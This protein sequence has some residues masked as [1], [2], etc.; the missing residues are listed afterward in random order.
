MKKLTL[1]LVFLLCGATLLAQTYLDVAP[2]YGTLNA[3]V[4]KNQGNVIYRLQAGQWYGLNGVIENNGFT[5]KIIGTTPAKGEMPAEIQTATQ[6]NGTV[7]SYMFNMIGNVT[8]KNVFIVNADANNSFGSGVFTSASTT[9]IKVVIDN[10]TVDPVGSAYGIVFNSTP[11][12]KLFI[13]NSLFIDRG[14]LNGANDGWF[15]AIGGAPNNGFDTLYVENNTFMVGGTGMGSLSSVSGSDSSNFVW[16]NHNSF[17]FQKSQ[18]FWAW[19]MNS[20]FVTNN[21]FFDFTTQPWNNK[22]NVFFP[23]GDTAGTQSRLSLVNQDT[24]LSDYT[25]GVLLSHRKLFVEYNSFYTDP[26]IQAYPTTWAAT[27]TKNND[28]V[29]PLDKAYIMHLMYPSDSSGVNREARMSSDKAHFPNFYEGNYSDNFVGTN[30]PNTDPQWT[31]SKFYAIQDSLVLWTL[32][33][34]ELNTWGFSA[35][36]VSPQ[37]NQIGNWFWNPDSTN[38]GN[39]IKWPRLNAGYTN[40]TMLTQSIAGLPLGDLNWFP[41]AKAAWQAHKKAIMN[42]ILAENVSK[43][44]LVVKEKAVSSSNA[45]ASLGASNVLDNNPNDFWSSVGHLNANAEEWI[46]IDQGIPNTVAKV[47]LV[48]RFSL[49]SVFCFPQDFKIQY[50]SDAVNW[51][52]IPGQTYTNYPNPKNNKGEVFVFSSP[53]NKRYIRIDATKLRVD[54]TGKTYYFQ[55]AEMHL[56]SSVTTLNITGSQNSK[57]SLSEGTVLYNFQSSV[58]GWQPVGKNISGVVNIDNGLYIPPLSGN[59]LYLTTVSQVNQPREYRAAQVV[60]KSN[61]DLSNNQLV[62]AVRTWGVPDTAS[63]IILSG[64]TDYTLRIEVWGPAAAGTIS[65]TVSIG[66]DNWTFFSF[67][68]SHWA[69]AKN[70]TKIRIGIAYSGKNTNIPKFWGGIAAF[71]QIGLKSAVTGIEG[72]TNGNLPTKYELM[73]NYP[74]PFNPTTTINYSVA[75]QGLVT[76]N[77]YNMLGQRV[78][79]LVNK[80]QNTGRY[81]VNFDAL[82][83]ASG[84]YLYR[85]QSGNFSLTKKMILLK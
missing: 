27:H 12:P 35:N 30:P 84:V 69:Y 48:P 16:M 41:A 54:N 49:D 74:N 70:I 23:D 39:P 57:D 9:P 18:L 46:Y 55:L 21:L 4:S 17:I 7:L 24:S 76:L 71:D 82:K 73:Q 31:D 53:V 2:G 28:G 62:G 75:K 40:S 78:A 20:Y 19:H 8:L 37:P 65:D 22:W 81:S 79:T 42:Y 6:T 47:V 72:K 52:D 29:T 14:N 59:Y 38:Y 43:M 80:V 66:S 5:L 13:T 51:T 63:G 3:A 1:F 33:A 58:Q 56:S 32:P 36:N 60:L 44:S 15:W 77:V 61:L 25:N 26:R 45:A 64:T 67:D 50:S 11:Y 34:A 10:V 83:L 85:I 68:V